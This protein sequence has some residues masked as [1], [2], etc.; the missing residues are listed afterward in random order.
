MGA[1]RPLPPT[2][3]WIAAHKAG[4]KAWQTDC[5]SAGLAATAALA[6]VP[7]DSVRA[8]YANAVRAGLVQRSMLASRDF[9]HVI[10]ALE[11]LALGPL[12]R[13]V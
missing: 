13:R 3:V 6:A 11:L 10:G 5:L 4:G 2:E 7:F 1:A 9:E 12:A 8:H